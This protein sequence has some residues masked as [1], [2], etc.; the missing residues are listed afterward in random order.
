MID[1]AF[2]KVEHHMD[3]VTVFC[4]P[5]GRTFTFRVNGAPIFLVNCETRFA[6]EDSRLSQRAKPALFGARARFARLGV[7]LKQQSRLKNRSNCPS[8]QKAGLL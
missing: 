4:R 3:Q 6:I 2:T 5:S 8:G 1:S 7:F